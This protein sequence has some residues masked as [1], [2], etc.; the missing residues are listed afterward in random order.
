MPFPPEPFTY[1][2]GCNC[3]SIRYRIAVP[4]EMSRPLNIYG[5]SAAPE[6]LP[7]SVICQCNDCRRT[8]GQA[9]GFALINVLSWASFSLRSQSEEERK[10]E[11]KEEK[12]GEERQEDW[13]PAPALFDA[14]TGPRLDVP[15]LKD[16]TLKFFRSSPNRARGF[17]SNCGTP[18]CYFAFAT[19]DKLPEG[20]YPQLDI[21]AGTVDRGDL[22]KEWFRPEREL[23]TDFGLEWGMG[24]TK[25][26]ASGVTRC[27][28]YKLED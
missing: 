8:H 14:T 5:T 9:F 17:C 22:E 26:G 20:W 27:R 2:G 3:R 16:S 21:W 28:R 18:L 13:I 10:E 15:V 11:H 1:H 12:V 24:I 7:M 4:A 23:W 25:K 6:R 19:P